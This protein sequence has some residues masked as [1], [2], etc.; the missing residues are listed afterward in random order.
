MNCRKH[1][2]DLMLK[3]EI[4]RGIVIYKKFRICNSAKI[5]GLQKLSENIS[6]HLLT[7]L[8]ISAITYI[9][10]ESVVLVKEE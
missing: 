6:T 1:W 5:K 4:V 10:K 2:L 3:K 8:T 7:V 9:N